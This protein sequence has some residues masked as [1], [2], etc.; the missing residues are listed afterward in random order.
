MRLTHADV[1]ERIRSDARSTGF[2][3]L[4]ARIV[5]K[6]GHGVRSCMCTSNDLYV[7]VC[8]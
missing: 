7:G 5:V 1:C 8:Q 4:V 3:S 2:R 6:L